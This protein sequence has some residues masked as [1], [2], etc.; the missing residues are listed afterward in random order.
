MKY[1]YGTFEKL[2]GWNKEIVSVSKLIKEQIKGYYGLDS[3]VIYNGIDTEKFKP[4]PQQEA[5]VILDLPKENPIGIFVGRPKYSKGFDIFLKVAKAN[6]DINFLCVTDW[7]INLKN[8]NILV[9]HNIPNNE[10]YKYY[11][12]SD[13][14][15][16]PSRFEGCSYV[17]LEAMACD[18]PVVASKTGLFYEIDSG[19]AGYV[20]SSHDSLDYIKAIENL[21]SSGE[22]IKPRKFVKENFSFEIF[23]DNYRNFVENLLKS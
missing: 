6:K 5:R 1:V 7:N 16:F 9:R 2:S 11:S 23:S 18:L 19:Q 17:P 15:I 10:M 13:F 8:K 22:K 3:T 20:I 4:I 12:A 21:L 14:L